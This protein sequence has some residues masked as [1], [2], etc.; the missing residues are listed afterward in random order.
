MNPI[1]LIHLQI[2]LE[3]TLDD[4]GRL[5]PI[6]GLREQGL[7]IVYRYPG[8]YIPYFCHYLSE[9]LCDGLRN[10]GGEQAFEIPMAIEWMIQKYLP[11]KFGGCFISEHLPHRPEPSEF[12]LVVKR[13]EQ[14]VVLVDDVPVCRAW[15]EHSNAQCAE[16][17]V[18]THPEHR[19]KGY[20]RQA[21]AAW[22]YDVIESGR[23][24]LYSYKMDNHASKA[25]VRS[26]GAAW[27]ADVVC[28]A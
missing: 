6:P 13:G 21:V 23:V 5:V 10:L 9:D 24:A 26:L 11:G 14:L 4:L 28:Y 1:D 8:G 27:Y 3:Y 7:Y 18:E 22:A 17:A 19:G 15:S 12:P 16:V 20:A 25:L 2:T